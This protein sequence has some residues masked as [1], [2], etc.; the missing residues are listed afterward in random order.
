MLSATVGSLADAIP[1][2]GDVPVD[3]GF[4]A[5]I[6]PVFEMGAHDAL[7]DGVSLVIC[8]AVGW[9]GFGF[10]EIASTP[11]EEGI[12][13]FRG[14]DSEL[15][16]VVDVTGLAG[17]GYPV[18]L[19]E[20]TQQ[21]EFPGD[22]TWD[23]VTPPDAELMADGFD[24]G[25]QQGDQDEACTR[26]RPV[27]AAF[28][29]GESVATAPRSGSGAPAAQPNGGFAAA[30]LWLGSFSGVDTDGAKLPGGKRRTR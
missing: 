18:P 6:F 14:S 19:L 7:P 5:E 17:M 25:V 16:G 8:P 20:W 30:M 12:D 13:G 26:E 23:E 4:P 9:Q 3:G 24:P 1:G 21:I 28:S 10:P 2:E 11:M 22:W 15:I 27:F 29:S